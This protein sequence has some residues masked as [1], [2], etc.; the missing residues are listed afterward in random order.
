MLQS[1]IDCQYAYALPP[2]R[3]RYSQ[4][5]RY[6]S[7]LMANMRS[8]PADGNGDRKHHARPIPA[9][10]H[11][12]GLACVVANPRAGR[13]YKSARFARPVACSAR[14]GRC[15]NNTRSA[16]PVACFAR[17]GRNGRRRSPSRPISMRCC[18]SSRRPASMR[19]PSRRRCRE[20]SYALHVLTKVF[21]FF[22][23]SASLSIQTY[24]SF[25]HNFKL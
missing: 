19:C 5:A 15:C 1:G 22:S 17:A 11:P 7:S 2:C 4:L 12:G 23:Q 24:T 13:W 10:C 3:S 16:R 25:I 20:I 14:A 6:A 18:S 21:V 9:D 8:D